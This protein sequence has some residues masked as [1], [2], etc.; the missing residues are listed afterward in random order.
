M[1]NWVEGP[2]GEIDRSPL[3]D[4]VNIGDLMMAG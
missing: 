3:I 4:K 2:H 1:P